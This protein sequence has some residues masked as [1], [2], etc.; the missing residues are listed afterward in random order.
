[1]LPEEEDVSD[2]AGGEEAAPH[3]VS[4]LQEGQAGAHRG[5]TIPQPDSHHPLP[6]LHSCVFLSFM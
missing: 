5:L 6:Y 4:P 3:R 2:W 1:M